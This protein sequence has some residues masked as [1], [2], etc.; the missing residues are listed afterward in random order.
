MGNGWGRGARG[1]CLP[2][3]LSRKQRWRVMTTEAGLYGDS[4]TL[5]KD[6]TEIITIKCFKPK[7]WCFH[8]CSIL[9]TVVMPGPDSGCT[10]VRSNGHQQQETLGYPECGTRRTRANQPLLSPAGAS[11][12]IPGLEHL[13]NVEIADCR[14]AI[15]LTPTELETLEPPQLASMAARKAD[16]Q[17]SGASDGGGLG[18]PYS[19]AGAPGGHRRSRC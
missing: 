5:R 3:P 19:G 11:P 13:H 2:R 9:F 4:Q 6:L 1:V 7:S 17:I 15:T 12:D 10:S 8:T 16:S 18:L 14:S